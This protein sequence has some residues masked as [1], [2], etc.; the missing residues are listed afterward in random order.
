MLQTKNTNRYQ[1]C[2][3]PL[4]SPTFSS[5]YR[6][7]SWHLKVHLSLWSFRQSIDPNLVSCQFVS[8]QLSSVYSRLLVVKND[9]E[10]RHPVVNDGFNC[11]ISDYILVSWWNDEY[12]LG[13]GPIKT[14]V[15]SSI[16]YSFKVIFLVVCGWVVTRSDTKVGCTIYWRMCAR[17]RSLVS[18][19]WR[20]VS[21]VTLE[22]GLIRCLRRGSNLRE[23]ESVKNWSLCT[24]KSPRPW[25]LNILLGDSGFYGSHF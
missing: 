11:V 18:D 21:L 19:D 23:S 24:K 13:F 8:L 7:Q 25:W 5:I 20:R 2:H 12:V 15:S 6:T 16:F 3:P 1:P 10:N 14:F 4:Q 9:E 17:A 22:N